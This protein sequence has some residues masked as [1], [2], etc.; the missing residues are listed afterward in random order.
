MKEIKIPDPHAK[1]RI[2]NFILQPLVQIKLG[3]YTILLSFIVV[4]AL[5]WFLYSLLY[6]LYDM[7]LELTDLREQVDIV[8][9]SYLLKA[10]WIIGG[11]LIFYLVVTIA[12][13]IYYTHKLVGPTFAFRRHIGALIKGDYTS[14]VN[15][16]RGDAF[17]E[18][19]QD[20]NELAQTLQKNEQDKRRNSKNPPQDRASV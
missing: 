2:K 15:L 4:I 14:R 18:V 10:G 7:V 20:L 8:Q 16:R 13:S 1:R 17:G 9:A 12:I 5:T 19:A 3:I 6:P 11:S